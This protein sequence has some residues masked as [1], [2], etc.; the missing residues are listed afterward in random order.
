MIH[1]PFFSIACSHLFVDLSVVQV[2]FPLIQMRLPP[3]FAS[4]AM[5][6][7][8]VSVVAW[9][10]LLNFYKPPVVCRCKLVAF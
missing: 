3:E 4:L 1:C 7:S 5:A 2:F 10:L 9:S 6:L 8:S